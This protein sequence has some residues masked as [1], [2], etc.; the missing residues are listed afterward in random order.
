MLPI[1]GRRHWDPPAAGLEE[2]GQPRRASGWVTRGRARDSGPRTQ[3]VARTQSLH[4]A[5]SGGL[6]GAEVRD[7]AR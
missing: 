4:S 5:R 7:V 1:P 6:F 2:A 3:A